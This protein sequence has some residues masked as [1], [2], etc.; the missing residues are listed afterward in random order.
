MSDAASGPEASP[1]ADEKPVAGASQTDLTGNAVRG[2][3]WQVLSFGGGRLATFV[4]TL[5]LARLLDPEAFGLFAAALTFLSY[6]QVLLDFGMGSFLVY[7]QEEGVTDRVHTAFF[8]NLFMTIGLTALSAGLSPFTSRLLGASGHTAVFAV[9]SLYLLPQG[10]VQL[11][12]SLIQRDLQFRK[13]VVIDLSAALVRTGLSIGLVTAGAGV[14]AIVVGLLAGQVVATACSWT[15]VRY[16]PRWRIVG[17]VVKDM[18]RFGA[19][20]VALDF[21][22]QLAL[23]SDYLIVGAV[24]GDVALGTY[25]VAFR[26][27]DLLINNVLWMFSAVAFPIYSR[28]RSQ[29]VEVLVRVVLKATRLTTIYGFAVG[30]GTAIAA[31]DII[32]VVFGHQWV[33]A[34]QTMTVVSLAAAVLSLTYASGPVFPAIGRPGALVRISLPMTILT[35]AGFI[36]VAR[37][38]IV[39]VAVVHLVANVVR[40]VARIAYAN[41]ILGLSA[42]DV[43]RAVAPAFTIAA[44]IVGCALPVRLLLAPGWIALLAIVGSGVIGAI[45]GAG[46]WGRAVFAECW[47]LAAKLRVHETGSAAH[48]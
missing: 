20:G 24:L 3:G 9:M 22:N 23:N 46:V 32:L 42:R 7:D 21:L 4:T 35:F 15:L 2:F 44:G 5:V 6:L 39:W 45:V 37:Y 48:P 16:R 19:A 33:G 10:L 47:A 11:T 27:A 17:P 13:Q 43:I 25:S 8:M 30:L 40:V 41:H 12:E 28:S 31:P 36:A 1:V 29:G 14:W 38:G 34:I 18:L 26:M